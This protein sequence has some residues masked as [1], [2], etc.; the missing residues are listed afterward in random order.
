MVSGAGSVQAAAGGE[1]D[2]D[3]LRVPGCDV[4]GN[5]ARSCTAWRGGNSVTSFMQ[6][7]WLVLAAC[8]PLETRHRDGRVSPAH[9]AS[10]AGD[11]QAP[12]TVLRAEPKALCPLSLPPTTVRPGTQLLWFPSPVPSPGLQEMPLPTCLTFP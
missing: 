10:P 8:Y 1:K 2:A 9:M 3:R 5:S 12:A 6:S 7:A 4:G 11:T